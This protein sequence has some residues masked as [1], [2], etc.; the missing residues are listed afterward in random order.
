M[1][2]PLGVKRS[3]FI[4]ADLLGGTAN[5]DLTAAAIARGLADKI[6]NT[7][8]SSYSAG[9]AGSVLTAIRNDGEAFIAVF[10]QSID[11]GV[12][13]PAGTGI[14]VDLSIK[15]ALFVGKLAIIS[16]LLRV[17]VLDLF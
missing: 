13:T 6:N 11:R 7:D 4:G 8:D 14:D 9:F 15:F 1:C 5:S 2:V 3:K 10:N 16:F 12:V 17:I